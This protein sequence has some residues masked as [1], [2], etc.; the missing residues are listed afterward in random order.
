MRL[1]EKMVLCVVSVALALV[2]AAPGEV[3]PAGPPERPIRERPVAGPQ[4]PNRP[5]RLA[6]TLLNP[7]AGRQIGSVALAEQLFQLSDEQRT[8]L[9]E[10]ALQQQQEERK[11]L[12]TLDQQYADKVKGLLTDEQ[13]AQY[14]AVM[15]ALSRAVEATRAAEAG[16]EAAVGRELAARARMTAMRP[17][18]QL[19]RLLDLTDEQQQDLMRLQR[20]RADKQAEA[21]KNILRPADRQDREAWR[22]YTEEIRAAMAAQDA[23]YEAKVKNILTP[24]QAKQLADLETALETYRNKVTTAQQ[25]FRE[26]LVK[27]LPAR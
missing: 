24:E 19:V 10:V 8:Q 20:E 22:K 25:I 7:A 2:A 17:G 11:L 9:D 21:T 18:P 13:K 4:R 14:D 5:E 16:L 12:D 26:D 1:A 27:A 6:L 15:A 23:E 3:E